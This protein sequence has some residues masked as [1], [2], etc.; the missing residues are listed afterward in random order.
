M[1]TPG[2]GVSLNH[3]GKQIQLLINDQFTTIVN[4]GQLFLPGTNAAMTSG[5]VVEFVYYNSAWYAT[6]LTENLR[7]DI[8]NVTVLGTGAITVGDAKVVIL[9][10]SGGSTSVIMG[11][12]GGYPGQMVT[13]FKTAAAVITDTAVRLNQTTDLYLCGGT[14]NIVLN[15]SMGYTFICD[16]APRFR[17]IS[18][19]VVP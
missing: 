7:S 12:S 1:R 14:S 13:L 9:T 15:G 4:G 6:N 17:M 11:L 10:G 19:F 18:P 16:V 2:G 8:Q 5:T 3:Q